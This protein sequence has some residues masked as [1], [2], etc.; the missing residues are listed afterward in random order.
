MFESKSKQTTS[1]Q[2][3]NESYDKKK[4][5]N[6]LEDREPRHGDR[7]QRHG[8]RKILDQ[9]ADL[10]NMWYACRTRHGAFQPQCGDQI[11]CNYKYPNIRSNGGHGVG[12]L[13][14]I[15]TKNFWK[16]RLRSRVNWSS[17]VEKDIE[18]FYLYPFGLLDILMSSLVCMDFMFFQLL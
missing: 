15:A 6:R 11:N 9:W 16:L 13:K 4:K 5:K 10:E 12:F 1:S 17:R 14:R 3:E 2:Q 7:P 8:K 18:E